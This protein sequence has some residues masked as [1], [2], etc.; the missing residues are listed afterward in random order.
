MKKVT[1]VVAT[2]TGSSYR[3]LV[4]VNVENHFHVYHLIEIC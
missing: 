2:D 4:L 1:R 3:A